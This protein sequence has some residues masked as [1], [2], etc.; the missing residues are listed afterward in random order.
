MNIAESAW[1]FQAEREQEF[2]LLLSLILVWP[3]GLSPLP[4]APKQVILTT[5][6][7]I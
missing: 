1:E 3:A 2:E 6:V 5:V 7:L 4:N